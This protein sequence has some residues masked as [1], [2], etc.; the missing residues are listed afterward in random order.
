MWDELPIPSVK[1][2]YEFPYIKLMV[3]QRMYKYRLYPSAKQK[4]RLLKIFKHCKFVYNEL[5]GLNEKL[6]VTKKF[7]FDSLVKDIKIC[8]PEISD[9]VHSQ[10]LQNVGDRLSKAFDNFF[11]RIKERKKGKKV[12]A[13]FP[14]FKSRIQSIIYPQSGFKFVSDGKLFCSKIGNI[15]I[16]L[17]RIPRGKAKT[18]AIKVNN[19][20]QWFAV[21][22][23]EV[24]MPVVEHPNKD[25]SVGIDVGLTN[26]ATLTNGTSIPNP[27]HLVRAERKLKRL[28]RRLSRKVKGSKNRGKARFR[29][30]RQHLKVANQRSDFLH[31]LSRSLA[32]RYG[33]ISVEDLNIKG[34]V[35]NHC[36][37]KHISDASWGSFKQML[38]YKEVALGGQL[39]EKNP[40]GTS[41]TCSGCG[42]IMEMPLKKKLFTCSRCGLSL[43]R[44]INASFNIQGRAG[45][46][47]TNSPVDIEPLSPISGRA[48]SMVEAGT[49][50][51]SR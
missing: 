28:Q 20:G 1:F 38:S 39:I 5:L 31:K 21:F 49:I 6:W 47:R 10:V 13:G 37:A 25:K 50:P 45:L 27:H 11:R 32:L 14:R 33:K 8:H 2:K 40:R 7:D 43:H 44:D 42:N 35:R 46:A 16:I 36:V 18:L 4:I 29:L 48:S 9:E 15:P 22:S 3:V 30:A 19:A 23:C 24:E 41:Q 34:M 12:N 26:F 51:N 17:H